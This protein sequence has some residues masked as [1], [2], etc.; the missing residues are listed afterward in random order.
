[1]IGTTV[2]LLTHMCS[3]NCAGI[4]VCRG[5][6]STCLEIAYSSAGQGFALNGTCW[7]LGITGAGGAVWNRFIHVRYF[8]AVY[9][10]AL[11]CRR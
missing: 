3:N 5:I 7:A 9:I 4:W 6:R 11:F 2:G 1:M 10:S 8:Q